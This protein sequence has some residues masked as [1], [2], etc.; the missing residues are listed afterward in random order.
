MN[1][2]PRWVILGFAQL[3]RLMHAA[4]TPQTPGLEDQWT[5]NGR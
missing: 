1:T 3:F 4:R 5:R 2:E